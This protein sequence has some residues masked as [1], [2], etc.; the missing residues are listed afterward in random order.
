MC[1]PLDWDDC[2]KANFAKFGDLIDQSKA[3]TG[4]KD[5]E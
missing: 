1:I 5:D 4:G 3:L 2:L